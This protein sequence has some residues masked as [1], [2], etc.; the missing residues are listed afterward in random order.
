MKH[1]FK[2]IIILFFL[3]SQVSAKDIFVATT[4]DDT[5]GTG[6]IDQPYKTIQKAASLAVAGDVGPVFPLPIILEER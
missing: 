2:L 6:K 4:V 3:T 1:F 5:S